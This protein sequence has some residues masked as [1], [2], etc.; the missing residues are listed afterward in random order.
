MEK[1]RID[2][3][4]EGK[5]MSGAKR[6]GEERGE[7]VQVSYGE[8]IRHL[9]FFEIRTGFLRGEHYHL[10]KEEIFYIVK[11]V[12]RGCFVDLDTGEKAEVIL[13]KGQRARVKPRCWHSFC[14]LEDASVVEYSPQIYDSSDSYRVEADV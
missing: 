8:E 3:L 1:V 5:E 4:P 7:F 10:L 2:L 14:G 9:A 13:M 12:V 6:W 11:G